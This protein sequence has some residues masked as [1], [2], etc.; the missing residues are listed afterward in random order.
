MGSGI[1][2]PKINIHLSIGVLFLIF[3]INYILQNRGY[4]NAFS[5]NYLDD[6]LAMPIILY[7]AQILMRLV[8][9]N[10]ALK[11]DLTMHLYGFALVSIAF[12]WILPRYYVHLTADYWDIACYALGTITFYLINHASDKSSS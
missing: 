3:L 6:L 11:L 8:Y 10:K 7:L 2:H 1:A 9:Q 4:S 12:E 5:R